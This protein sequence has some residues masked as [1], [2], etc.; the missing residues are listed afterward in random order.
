M[1]IL[2]SSVHLTQVVETF[3][4]AGYGSAF[5]RTLIQWGRGLPRDGRPRMQLELTEAL[6]LKGENLASAATSTHGESSDAAIGIGAGLLDSVQG[7]LLAGLVVF[8]GGLALYYLLRQRRAHHHRLALFRPR[9]AA[10]AL[11]LL[12]APLLVGWQSAD[13]SAA[14]RA[15]W[16]GVP[17]KQYA[18][19]KQATQA[20]MRMVIA[21]ALA[22]TGKVPGGYEYARLKLTSLAQIQREV[23]LPTAQLTDGMRYALKTYGLDGWGRPFRVRGRWGYGFRITSAGQDGK[24]GTR[25]DH[26]TRVHLDKL[27]EWESRRRAFFLREVGGELVVLFHRSKMRTFRFH[28]EKRAQ[29]ATKTKLFDLI[30]VSKLPKRQQRRLRRIYE[31]ASKQRKNPLVAMAF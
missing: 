20:L 23:G 21:D 7:Q 30:P 29:A 19:P 2:A 15:P 16:D 10:L 27:Y 3:L 22:N 14:N 12:A 8:F 4:H 25:D 13:P 1:K 5:P 9:A 6:R 26:K 17:R 11:A 28:D 18:N 31:A 24:Y